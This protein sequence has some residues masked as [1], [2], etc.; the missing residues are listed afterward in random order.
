MVV[1]IRLHGSLAQHYAGEG[2]DS[3]NGITIT[4]PQK[5][6]SM[7]QVFD[8]LHIPVEV[9]GLVAINGVRAAKD[10]WVTD[11]DEIAIFP[12]VTGG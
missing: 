9:V 6:V 5:K 1:Q 2:A 8:R 11:E 10:T 12:L 4:F 7:T 3:G